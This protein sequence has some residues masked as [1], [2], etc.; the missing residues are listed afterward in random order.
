MAKEGNVE[1]SPS[2]GQSSVSEAPASV[3]S[4]SLRAPEATDGFEVSRLIKR[5]PPLDTN[6]TYCN[7]LQCSHFS[8]TSVIATSEQGVV[9]FVSGYRIPGREDTLFIWQVAVDQSAR[10]CGLAKKMLNHILHRSDHKKV[11][12][13]ETTITPGNRASEGLFVRWAA[14]LNGELKTSVLFTREGHFGGEH[15]QEV[16]HRI[17]PFEV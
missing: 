3:G 10:G 17:G 13:I 12:F 5:C 8:R 1:G 15:D 11:C 16:L 7:L 6:S 2:A 14:Q 4:I 9:G